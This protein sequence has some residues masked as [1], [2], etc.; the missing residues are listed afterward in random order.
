MSK[1]QEPREERHRVHLSVRYET[2]VDFVTEYAQNL[3][4]GGLFIQ[5][6]QN[7][8][9]RQQVNVEL[10]LPGYKSFQL[11]AE[12]VHILDPESADAIGRKPGTGFTIVKS[13][14]GFDKAL[15]S[16]LERLGR[17]KDF[18]VLAANQ[19]CLKMIKDVGFQTSPVPPTSQLVEV[20]KRSK[21]QVIAVVVSKEIE[22]EYAAAAEAGGRPGLVYGID[23]L[24]E[25]DGLIPRLD[26]ALL[27]GGLGMRILVADDWS[28]LAMRSS[29]LP[30]EMKLW[31]NLFRNGRISSF[32]ISSFQGCWEQRCARY[33]VATKTRLRY[34]SLWSVQVLPRWRH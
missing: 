8:H 19:P 6:D 16:Y 14:S 33:C 30:Q 32:S 1:D 20:I 34:P 28:E 11:A 17:R 7:L 4:V 23:F 10:E 9:L 5:G 27:I 13:P 31:R 22:H 26:E 3:S 21:D 15:S 18:V 12:V 2:A 29:Q 24:E 25:I